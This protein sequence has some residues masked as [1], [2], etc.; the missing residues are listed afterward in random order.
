MPDARRRRR[1]AIAAGPPPGAPGRWTVHGKTRTLPRMAA[2][3]PASTAPAVA[4]AAPDWPLRLALC[5]VL[6]VALALRVWRLGELPPGLHTDE[7]HYAK[8]ALEI[9]AGARPLF[10]VGN[11]GREPLFSYVVAAAF[12]AWGVSIVSL[13][14]VAAFAGVVATALTVAVARRAAGHAS[15]AVV[16]LAAV[17]AGWT[18]WPVLQSRVGL[19]LVLLPVWVGLLVVAWSR[20]LDGRGGVDDGRSAAGA[21]AS[22]RRHSER[23][24]G[25]GW[26]AASGVV[27]AGAFY[28]HLTGRLLPLV[29]LLSGAWWAWRARR[30]A[31]LGRAAVAVA[32]AALL[33][34]PLIGYLVRH[35]EQAG[36]RTGQVSILNPEVNDGHPVD[37]LVDN[38]AALALAPAWRGDR[39]RYHNL[40]RRPVF[41]DPLWAVGWLVGLV[42]VAAWAAGRRGPRRQRHG[43]LLLVALAVT[44]VPSWLSADAP[45]FLR[46]TGTWPML[47]AVVAI[48]LGAMAGAVRDG[49]GRAAAA[50]RGAGGRV[51]GARDGRRVAAGVL[52]AAAAVAP[53]AGTVRD[54][55]GRYAADG[56][57]PG[58]YN[59]A[60]TDH[61]RALAEVAA[62][63]PTFITPL[64]AGQTAIRVLAAAAAP[65]AVDPATGL[66]LPPP[67]ASARYVFDPLES[68]AAAA[69]GRRWPMATARTL[70]D[71]RGE[72][73]VTVFTF[74]PA[75]VA[76]AL[77]A[78]ASPPLDGPATFGGALTLVGAAVA[79][80]GVGGGRALTATLR[81]D[82]VA[83][84]AVDHNL[85]VHAIDAG[86][87]TV[88]QFDGP[89]LGGTP[90]TDR[91]PAGARVVMAVPLAANDPSARADAADLAFATGWYDW[92]T[93]TRLPCLGCGV[94]GTA[95]RIGAGGA[96]TGGD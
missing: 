54:Y 9:M 84:T 53:L 67:G 24:A 36:A 7:G 94:D 66:L 59:A 79:G 87:R 25:L 65:A 46:L 75:A 96:G 63:G 20:A 64:L 74:D 13:R 22:S 43:A 2:G 39:N 51:G 52:V 1:P 85:F 15:R 17:G 26:A 56:R 11:N 78:P 62:A 10:L 82:V 6:V 80:G 41:A 21:R 33:A 35:P 71:R 5:G 8:D 88:A 42:A 45:N 34:A 12:G 16:V 90:T 69:F 18:F 89:P 55:F 61:G 81:L 57:L 60:A 83:P 73:S 76:A 92:R 3:S 31:A 48:G 19:R 49:V 93:G 72:P 70:R 29:P 50:R 37:A 95:A 58:I 44:T 4:P 68:A 32:V 40:P 28:T 91:W 86:G 38:A 47:F 14:L 23:H 30:P 27:L 77:A